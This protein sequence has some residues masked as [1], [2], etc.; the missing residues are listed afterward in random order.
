MVTDIDLEDGEVICSKCKG[1]GSMPYI[2]DE[3][4]YAG[5]CQKCHGN[6]KLDW[7][8][9]I[10]GL[11]P[12]SK[13]HGTSGGT[14]GPMGISSPTGISQQPGQNYTSSTRAATCSVIPKPG[15]NPDGI[16]TQDVNS[17][18]LFI[19]SK[20]IDKIKKVVD[21]FTGKKLKKIKGIV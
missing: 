21:I 16:A 19:R 1:K 12:K 17:G 3:L 7:I 18:K 9:D 8:S 14:S 2:D 6:G 15:P 5:V 10:M 13:W 20:Y 4:I 11:P